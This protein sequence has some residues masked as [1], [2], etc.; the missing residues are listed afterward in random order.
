MCQVFFFERQT[1]LLIRGESTR[2]TLPT[3]VGEI[4]IVLNPNKKYTD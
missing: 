2:D 3:K 1:I 4:H